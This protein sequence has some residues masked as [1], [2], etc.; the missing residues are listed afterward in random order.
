MFSS[1]KIIVALLISL[2][3]STMCGAPRSCNIDLSLADLGQQA[4]RSMSVVDVRHQNDPHVTEGSA[5]GAKSVPKS[6]N[7]CWPAGGPRPRALGSV[8]EAG[9]D[10]LRL[11]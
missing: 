10:G 1:P 2:P 9:G 8:E 11:P 4:G 6:G 7:V 3:G 5:E